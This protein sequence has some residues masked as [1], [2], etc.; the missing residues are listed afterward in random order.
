[1]PSSLPKV[2]NS[3]TSCSPET[4]SQKAS[5]IM[6][7]KSSMSPPNGSPSDF[8]EETKSPYSWFIYSVHSLWG[9]S[10]FN[11]FLV[12]GAVLCIRNTRY[13][14]NKV[15]PLNIIFSIVLLL[16]VGSSYYPSEATLKRQSWW[17]RMLYFRGQQHDEG[18]GQTPVQRSGQKVQKVGKSFYEW[19]EGAAYNVLWQSSWNWSQCGLL[20]INFIAVSTVSLHSRVC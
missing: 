18:S 8:S 1:M 15:S 9:T 13:V 14:T 11:F 20:S 6:P 17:K 10:I 16:K 7:T 5:C 3:P 4:H 12:L 2:F 19:K